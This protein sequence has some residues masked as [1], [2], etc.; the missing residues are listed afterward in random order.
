MQL[1]NVGLVSRN[2]A[3]QQVRGRVRGNGRIGQVDV[4]AKRRAGTRS[5]IRSAKLTA[6]RLQLLSPQFTSIGAD[7][8]A[9][10]FSL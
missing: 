4:P 9:H 3:A 5:R 6:Q 7:K 10:V 2:P 1:P 8:N